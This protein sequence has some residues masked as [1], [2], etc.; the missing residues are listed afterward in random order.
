MHS[1]VCPLRAGFLWRISPSN[2]C[3]QLAEKKLGTMYV[4]VYRF[5]GGV[6]GRTETFGLSGS[7]NLPPR[8]LGNTRRRNKPKLIRLRVRIRECPAG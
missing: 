3:L 8:E 7:E 1:K 5:I 2:T 4:L 6:L